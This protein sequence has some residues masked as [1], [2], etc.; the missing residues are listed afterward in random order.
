VSFSFIKANGKFVHF[1][2]IGGI[3]MSGLAMILLKYNYKVSGSDMRNSPLIEKLKENGAKIYLGHNEDNVREAG[4][5]VYTAAVSEDNKELIKARELGLTVMDRAEFLGL[6]MK[7]FKYNIAISGTHG[8]TTTTSMI[9]LIALQGVLD[10]TI[11][12]GGELDA[13]DGN[14]RVG[15]SSYFIAEACEYKA[16]FLKFY[17]YIGIILNIDSD[18]LDFY[19]DIDDINQTFI[20]FSKL[21]PEDGY[22]I[23]CAEDDRVLSLI[24]ASKC[25]TLSYG[26]TK[27]DI[28]AREISFDEMGCAHFT[29]YN[30]GVKFFDIKLKVP[31][32]H[33]ILNALASICAS[34]CLKL[35]K[36]SIKNG[37]TSYSGTHKRFELKGS[38]KGVTIID[39]YAHHPTEIKAALKTAKLYPHKRI[40]CVFQP[41]TY[42]RTIA[43]FE[44]FTDSFDLVDKLILADIYAAREIDTKEVSSD[45][46]GDKLREKGVSCLNFHDF[47][48]IVNYLKTELKEG[49]LLLTVGAGDVVKIGEK[50]L[51]EK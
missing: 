48:D 14:F 49:D 38:Y 10:P 12:L 47:N 29:V 1:I 16:S 46:L 8:K 18:H 34:L 42:S 24:K 45:M 19:K 40:I 21:I 11:M 9:S 20:K 22:L 23:G 43:L 25:N 50:L 17:P 7:N 41:H 35:D 33:N 2:G 30:K 39:D 51:E 6:L 3:S 15:K 37:L 26:F 44:E 13:I 36:E 4:F 27:G 32:E 31:G 5:V 28:T